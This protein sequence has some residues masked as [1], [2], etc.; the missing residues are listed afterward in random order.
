MFQVLYLLIIMCVY[1]VMSKFPAEKGPW[2]LPILPENFVD[3]ISDGINE[4]HYTIAAD[5]KIPRN[6]WMGFREV[7]P[8]NRMYPH[9]TKMTSNLAKSNWSVNFFGDSQIDGF[10]RRYYANTSLLWAYELINPRG[11]I[12]SSDI[13]RYSALYAFGGFY[14]DDDASILQ[15]LED[16]RS[17]LSLYNL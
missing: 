16:V 13:W 12:A 6:L 3:L 15:D 1:V 14:I 11:R 9:V 8:K 5:K 10:M 17:L 4:F 2:D 7:P